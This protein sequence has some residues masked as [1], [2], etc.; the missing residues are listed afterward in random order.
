MCGLF[1]TIMSYSRHWIYIN[2]FY[3]SLA[4][5]QISTARKYPT[6]LSPY[7]MRDLAF[8][9]SSQSCLVLLGCSFLTNSLCFIY[10]ILFLSNSGHRK[11]V[12]LAESEVTFFTQFILI[13]SLKKKPFK[14]Q[15]IVNYSTDKKLSV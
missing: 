10:L 1:S 2:H 15:N 5:F 4:H 13:F 3:L 7:S 14:M 9:F 12:H 8:S 6:Q 11:S